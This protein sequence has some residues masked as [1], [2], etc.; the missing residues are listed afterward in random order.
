MKKNQQ[1]ILLIDDEEIV[2]AM[3]SDS[4]LKEGYKVTTALTAEEGLAKFKE[5]PCDLVITD[6]IMEKK[7]GLELSGEIK[8]LNPA[9]PIMILTGYPSLNTA[10]EALKLG[11]SD[12]VIKP[13][14]R[15]ELLQK[16]Q[17]CLKKVDRPLRQ[18]N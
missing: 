12:Y 8:K 5:A 17:N 9:T 14:E 2:L 11:A 13:C 15:K 3:V 4:L 10:I 1:S 18:G 16:V 7:T 6:L